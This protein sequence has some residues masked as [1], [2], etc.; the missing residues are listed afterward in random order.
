[1]NRKK[2]SVVVASYNMGKYLALAIRSVLAQTYPVYEIN[3]VDDGSTDDTREIMEQFRDEPRVR[4]H[5]QP[6][7]GQAVAKN[8]GIKE[9][10][11]DYIAFCDADDMWTPDKLE[12]QLPYFDQDKSIGVVHTN[13]ILMAED[14]KMLHTP[15]RTYFSGWIS[16]QLLIDNCVNGMA[17]IVRRECFDTVGMFDESLPMGIDYDLWLRISAHYQFL[18][19]DVVTYLYRQWEGQM[20][21]RHTKR[22]ECAVKI[23]NKF[24]DSHPKLIDDSTVR[25]AWAHTYVGR[26]QNL[27]YIDKKK[28][29]GL[30]LFLKALRQK[31]S[32]VPAWKEI[33]KLSLLR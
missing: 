25:E 30:Q 15:A 1:M 6:N 27:V 28:V 3:V 26:G 12:K 5:F 20:S 4:Y 19:I 31:P 14:G 24:L 32:Y 29:Q 22:Y 18:F 11:G 10:C 13:F 21:H 16:G 2:V 23:M 7:Q 33:V 9:S 17:S 8:R